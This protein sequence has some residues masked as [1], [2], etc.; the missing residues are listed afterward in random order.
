MKNKSILY[1]LL[2]ILGF[3]SIWQIASY[4]INPMLL[5]SVLTVFDKIIEILKDP[6][7][8]L[9]IFITVKRLFYGILIGISTGL[10]LGVIMGKWEALKRLL[11]PIISVF[12]TV[13]PVSWLVMSLVWFGFNGKPA[14]FIVATSTIPIIAIN[15]SEGFK[16]IDKNLME[17]AKIYKFSQ[18][19]IFFN[20]IGPTIM[21]FFK[22][23]CITGLGSGWKIAVMGEVLTTTD[24]IGGMIKL[25]RVNI[26]PDSLMAWSIIIVV[27]FY[28]SRFILNL[29]FGGSD[30]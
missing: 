7:S 30:A 23:A 27:L 3:L 22:S 8:I 9:M 28:I 25:A 20:I 29:L 6:K 15:I 17:M 19:K 10:I 5:P 16:N 26:E 18:K 13:P 2:A 14:I 24:G 4:F 12:Q 1:D 21:P 11:S